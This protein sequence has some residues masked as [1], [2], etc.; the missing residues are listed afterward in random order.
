MTPKNS[1]LFSAHGKAEAQ[2][3]KTWPDVVSGDPQIEEGC[4][5]GTAR[6]KRKDFRRRS[7]ADD[8]IGDAEEALLD[9]MKQMER[10]GVLQTAN[11]LNLEESVNMPEEQVREQ[12]TDEEIKNAVQEKRAGESTP[13]LGVRIPHFCSTACLKFYLVRVHPRFRFAPPPGPRITLD[14]PLALRQMPTF[15][16]ISTF[17]LSTSQPCPR[18]PRMAPA[19]RLRWTT[20]SHPTHPRAHCFHILDTGLSHF[21]LPLLTVHLA[22]TTPTSVL[23]ASPPSSLHLTVC[24]T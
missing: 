16:V 18:T 2:R 19:L 9:V 6:A 1:P 14:L 22:R 5:L 24:G 8:T 21:H 11:M 13:T 20:T 17:A 3:Y 4:A 12:L 10:T 15:G 23:H 7:D